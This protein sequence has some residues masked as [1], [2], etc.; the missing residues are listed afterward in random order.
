M[1]KEKLE[2]N[3]NNV[4]ETLQQIVEEKEYTYDEVVNMIRKVT[5]YTGSKEPIQA[6]I[7]MGQEEAFNKINRLLEKH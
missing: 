1:S 5:G 3:E 6:F 4:L 2:W 7:D